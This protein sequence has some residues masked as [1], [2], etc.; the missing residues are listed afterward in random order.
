MFGLT[1]KINGF[2]LTRDSWIFWWSKVIG[3][4]AAVTTGVVDPAVFGLSEKQK[5]LVMGLCAAIVAIA[6]QCSTSNLPSKSDAQKV[7][8]H[9]EVKP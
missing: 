3:L 2:V 7:T 6:A 8:V 1:T 5:H 9:N 4:A